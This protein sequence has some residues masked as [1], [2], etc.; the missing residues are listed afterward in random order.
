MGRR[1]GF[2]DKKNSV[3]YSLIHSSAPAGQQPEQLWVEKSRGVTVG[4]PDP[5]LASEPQ[6]RDPEYYSPEHPLAFLSEEPTDTLT[7]EQRKEIVDLGLP[8]DGYDYLKHLRDPRSTSG[9]P[10]A[11]PGTSSV[12]EGEVRN[13]I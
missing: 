4:R 8:D 6:S 10:P 9:P 5:A 11:E 7:E 12:N 2:F 3:T 13:P 1:K